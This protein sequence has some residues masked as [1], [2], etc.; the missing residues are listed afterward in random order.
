MR[1]IPD[2]FLW[3]SGREFLQFSCYLT[4]DVYS[5][6]SVVQVGRSWL[7]AQPAESL[8]AGATSAG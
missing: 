8:I 3:H 1:V 2:H 7:Y 5:Q 6:F 4:W